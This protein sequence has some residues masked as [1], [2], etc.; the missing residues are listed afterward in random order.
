VHVAR[1]KGSGG[2]RPGSGR[3]PDSPR[4]LADAQK[5]AGVLKMLRAGNSRVDTARL[6][7]FSGQ[8]LLNEME[9]DAAF[10][11]QVE[12]AEAIGKSVL[13]ATVN[14][15]A[16]KEKDWKAAAWLLERKYWQ[17]YARR[18]PKSISPEELA[19]VIGRIVTAF[20]VIVPAEFHAAIR[21]E[22]DKIVADAI[23]VK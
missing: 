2:K 8:T 16:T 23:Q 20:L 22:L 18:D 3:K 21:A 11:S 14:E 15:A 5:R 1:K 10:A 17:E 9:R 7:G 13:I 19:N 12:Q 4:I 6:I